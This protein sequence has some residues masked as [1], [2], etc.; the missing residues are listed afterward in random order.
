[1][2]RESSARAAASSSRSALA[3]GARSTPPVEVLTRASSFT[4]AKG[5]HAAV[6][7]VARY[8][9]LTETVWA[10]VAADGVTRVGELAFKPGGALAEAEG[11]P[12]GALCAARIAY[13]LPETIDPRQP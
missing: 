10:V 7:D 13:P 8:H 3:A 2:G 11:T 6:G 9:D 12:A 5:T 4:A 1:M